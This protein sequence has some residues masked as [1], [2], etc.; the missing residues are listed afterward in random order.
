MHIKLIEGVQRRTTKLVSQLKEMNYDD[1]SEVLG[2]QRFVDRRIRG[3]MIETYKIMT[4][5]EELDRRRLFTLATLR[6]RAHPMKIYRKYSQLDVRKY[7]FSLRVVKKWNMLSL[8]EVESRKASGFKAKYD[9][10]E[11]VRSA[12]RE[13]GIYVWE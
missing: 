1:R 8:D 13:N 11:E 12:A 10:K 3:D 5:K 6:N 2:L 9:K 7:F 4:G